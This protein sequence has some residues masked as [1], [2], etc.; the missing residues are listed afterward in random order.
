MTYIIP[1]L[2]ALSEVLTAAVAMAAFSVFLFS[3][4]FMRRKQKLAFTLV[5]LLLCVAVI[6]SADALETIAE[7]HDAKLMWQLIHWTGFVI[8]PSVSLYFAMVLLEMTGKKLSR[9]VM[10]LS[11]LNIILSFVFVGLLWGGKLF[12]GIRVITN[13]GTTMEHSGLT[14]WFWIYFVLNLAGILYT[15]KN[16]Y[17]RTRTQASR[18]RMIYLIAGLLGIIVG[19]FPLLLF[20]S[21]L[22]ISQ[23]PI[24]F[25]TL[26]VLGNAVVTVMVILLGYAAANFSVPWSDRFTRLRLIEW[27]LRGPVTASMTLWLV[28]MINRSGDVLGLNIAGLSTLAAVVSI[29]LLEYL[30]GVI[31]PYIERGSLVGLGRE[32]YIIFNEFKGMMVFKPELE[33]Y[34]EALTGA[35]CD[36]F[37]SRD[38]F[39]AVADES[40]N[41]D[42][43]I[44][45]GESSWTDLP[46]MLQKLPAYF[47]EQGN[48]PFQDE[49]GMVFPLYNHDEQIDTFLGVI[50]FSD[51]T[52]DRLAGDHA[53]VLEDAM[54]KAGT[55][56]WER[57]YLTT[58]YQVLRNRTQSSGEGFRRGSVLNQNA[59]LADS[60]TPEPEEVSVWVKDALTHYWG[61]PKLTE[62]PL[63]QWKIVRKTAAEMNDNEVN[64]LRSVLKTALEELKPEGERSYGTEGLFYNLI[65]YKFFEK[66][67]VRDVARRLSMSEPDFYRKQKTAV[68]ELTKV[69]IRMEQ[70]EN[71]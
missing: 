13:I 26:S 12:S 30:T 49:T 3:L 16:A 56:L 38:G 50:G 34:L 10:I 42:P 36:R 40:G 6:Y 41:F 58:A 65:D 22:L 44:Q 47:A 31:M 33:T 53:Q 11:W 69:I 71:G 39:F 70:S 4:Q 64:A 61:G 2:R 25:W 63:L 35:L 57:R 24:I 1:S 51:I 23:Y 5:P 55:V 43:I 28:T 15:L 68:E 60:G 27:M 67:K 18:R 46:E 19:T 59:L 62:N 37:Q 66:Q 20:G 52:P 21:G 54:E 48:T 45:T 9:S 32:D 29:I 7:G 17:S 8:L 14:F